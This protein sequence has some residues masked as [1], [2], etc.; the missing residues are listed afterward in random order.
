MRERSGAHSGA[1]YRFCDRLHDAQAGSN[2]RHSSAMTTKEKYLHRGFKHAQR[3]AKVV[4]DTVPPQY[5][6]MQNTW[7]PLI[8][9]RKF[10]NHGRVPAR[11]NTVIP[12][13]FIEMLFS[14]LRY[15]YQNSLQSRT[16]SS[17]IVV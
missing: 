4:H 7:V 6:T 17:I 3:Y 12:V 10:L 2:S 16:D 15:L 5:H 9:W 1:Y 13:T 14:Y 11:G 8:A